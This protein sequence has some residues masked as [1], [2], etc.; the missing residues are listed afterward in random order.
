MKKTAREKELEKALRFIAEIGAGIRDDAKD[1][2]NIAVGCQTTAKKVL[3][4]T[5]KT[6]GKAKDFK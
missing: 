4:G 2:K 6:C 5:C 1:W 3:A